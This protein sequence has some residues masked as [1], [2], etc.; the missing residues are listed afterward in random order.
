MSENDFIY[1]AHGQ[2]YIL[3]GSELFDAP[4]GGAQFSSKSD[5]NV[6]SISK[7]SSSSGTLKS[8]DEFDFS[9][10]RSRRNQSWSAIDLHEY[11]VYT[12]ESSAGRVAADA[13]TQTDESL[14]RRRAMISELE[15][16]LVVLKK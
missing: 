7:R 5:E 14:R 13:S 10:D 1:P 16:V 11:K 12:G 2:E 9:V 4:G 3:K 8:I 6:S 15:E